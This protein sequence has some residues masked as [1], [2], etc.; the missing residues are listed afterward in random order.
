MSPNLPGPGGSPPAGAALITMVSGAVDLLKLQPQCRPVPP[1]QR[2]PLSSPGPRPC[3]LCSA[4]HHQSV[5][6]GLGLDTPT[7]SLTW[8]PAPRVPPAPVS[9]RRAPQPPHSPGEAQRWPSWSRAGDRE[10]QS[11]G[12][13]CSTLNDPCQ[14]LL[15]RFSYHPGFTSPGAPHNNV[16][17]ASWLRAPPPTPVSPVNGEG[18]LG[19]APR[20]DYLRRLF[21]LFRGP[22]SAGAR[23][24]LSC[25][26]GTKTDQGF[27]EVLEGH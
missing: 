12:H 17:R 6:Q 22:G 1:A 14:G 15:P 3:W 23:S 4:G 5:R 9:T 8:V 2:P 19:R 25:R 10:P 20:Q 26:T 18:A 7:P 13:L 27:L 24:S 21:H 16:T 11:Q